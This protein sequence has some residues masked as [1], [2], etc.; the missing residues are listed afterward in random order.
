MSSYRSRKECLEWLRANPKTIVPGQDVE[1]SVFRPEDAEGVARLYHAIYGDTFAIDSVYDPVRIAEANLGPDLHQYVARTPSGE[2]IGLSAL[3]RAAPGTGIL[4]A[5]GLMILPGYRGSSLVFT[6]FRA[7]MEELPRGLGLNALFGQSVCDHLMTQKLTRKFGCGSFALE[8]ESMPA[9]P[10]ASHDGV[11]GR[12]T[13]LDEFRVYHD[14]PHTVFLPAEYAGWL[15]E[16]YRTHGLTRE[17]GAGQPLAGS[18][19]SAVETMVAASVAKLV[20]QSPGEDLAGSIKAMEHAHPGCHVYQ[21]RLPLTHP[22]LPAAVGAARRLGYF[23]G[24]L[25]PLWTDQDV[26]LLQKVANEPDFARPQLLTERA[27]QLL[28]CVRQDRLTVQP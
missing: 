23:L 6:L 9:R 25:L 7:M 20:V 2:V 19:L 3:F 8:L 5:G 13:L 24:G 26:L 27:K 18:T 17:F 28:E 21:L 4:E 14:V 1:T 11:G 22:G 15:Q 16:T 12:I 10:E